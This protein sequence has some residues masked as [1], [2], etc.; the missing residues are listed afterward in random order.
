M[1]QLTDP[2]RSRVTPSDGVPGR[3]DLDLSE[4]WSS[5][6]GVHGGHLVALAVEVVAA[7]GHRRPVRTVATSF[8]RSARPG[9]A[10]AEIRVV[11]E[12]GLVT[13]CEVAMSQRGGPLLVSR[14][15]LMDPGEGPSWDTTAS[16]ELP[17][18]EA[19]VPRDPE[20]A[21]PRHFDRAEARFDPANPPLENDRARV[22]GY[23]RPWPGEAVDAAWLTMATDWF[24]PPAFSVAEPPVGGISVDLFTHLH[25]CD[26]D[27]AADEWL[28]GDF[29]IDVSAHGM[30]VEHGRLLT[31][32][33]AMVAES[34][35][36][37]LTATR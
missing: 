16:I 35:Q 13:I 36:T 1:T 22:R 29:G 26:I 34:F 6:V 4:G 2:H 27:L 24:P 17:P 37:R 23:I 21:L 5:L 20:R 3:F 33:G 9:P 7:A 30:A 19:C 32:R 18:P 31:Q 12:G 10:E 14:L 28:V 8:L 25:R 15:T 11:R